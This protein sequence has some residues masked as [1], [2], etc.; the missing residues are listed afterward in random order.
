M[1]Y[2]L[3][4]AAERLGVEQ[5][6]LRKWIREASLEPALDEFD[7]RR[8]LLTEDQ[9]QELA[10]R[11]RRPIVDASDLH[12]LVRSLQ[13]QVADLRQSVSGLEARLGGG[14]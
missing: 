8:K 9:L 10:H 13:R 2:T 4:E 5:K 12:A 14:K 1:Q 11:H 3:Q 6:T 7:L